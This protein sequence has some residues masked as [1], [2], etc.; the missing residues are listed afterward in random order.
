[1]IGTGV[2]AQGSHPDHHPRP[3]APTHACA[4]SEWGCR[5]AGMES[6]LHLK[7]ECPHFMVNRCNALLVQSVRAQGSHPACHPLRPHA[8]M[9][10]SGLEK[11]VASDT[12][13]VTFSQKQMQLTCCY[14]VFGRRGDIQTATP[15]APTRAWNVLD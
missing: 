13:I 1:M 11:Y 15:C 14:P 8:R 6:A 9:E 7:S 2:R 5:G 3:I 10:C 4:S 12:W